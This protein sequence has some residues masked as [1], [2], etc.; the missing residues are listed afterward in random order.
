M[1][2]HSKWAN[3]K[4]RKARIDAKRGKIFSKIA[5]ELMVA[6]REGGG[7]PAAN[8]SLRALVQKARSYNM[9]ADNVDRAIKKGTGEGGSNALEELTYEGYAPGGVAVLVQALTDNKN[10]TVAEVRNV[11]TKSGGS[12]AGLGAV[13]HLFERKG[14]I[15][16]QADSVEE[17]KLLVMVLEAGGEDV[18]KDGDQYEI[19][20]AP[21]EFMAV[22]D[23]LSGAGIETTGSELTF[24]AGTEV[25]VSD[26]AQAASLIRFIEALDDLDDVQNVYANFNID[27]EILDAVT[28]D[29]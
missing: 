2:G 8:I 15:F 17:D 29:S 28:S 4:H 26:E 12:L 14:Q 13:A 3:T 27:D 20:T 7:D 25:P 11:F 9:P 10:R 16:V 6:A 22:V 1:A 5:K 23:A 21:S 18:R 24:L 19:L